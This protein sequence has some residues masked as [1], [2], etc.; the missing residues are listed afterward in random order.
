M[1]SNNISKYYK[2]DGG[3][4][5]TSD[6]QFA[7]LSANEKIVYKPSGEKY[8]KNSNYSNVF[9][10]TIS[11]DVSDLESKV[12]T[13][14]VAKITDADANGSASYYNV[15]GN[16]IGEFKC[17]LPIIGSDGNTNVTAVSQNG[18]VLTVEV[19]R[20]YYDKYGRVTKWDKQTATAIV[21][22]GSSSGVGYT[23]VPVGTISMWAGSVS[24]IP[25]GWHLCDGTAGTPD[26]RD[27]FVIGAGNKYN[28]GSTGGSASYDL[29]KH[30]HYVGYGN[31]S[32]DGYHLGTE[33]KNLKSEL[34]TIPNAVVKFNDFEGDSGRGWSTI[35]RNSTDG[36]NG[37]NGENLITSL[38]YA[39]GT[40]DVSG[41]NSSETLPPYYALCYIMKV[42]TD[43]SPTV[44]T[45]N[46]PELLWGQ[47]LTVGEVD[48]KALTVRMPENPM[49]AGN[50]L[51]YSNN[52][53]GSTTG[54][55]L[56]LEYHNAGEETSN[57]YTFTQT[58][59]Y[60]VNYSVQSEV[61]VGVYNISS[62]GSNNTGT[63]TIIVSGCAWK[64]V[65]RI[66]IVSVGEVFEV[67]PSSSYLIRT[68]LRTNSAL[69]GGDGSMSDSSLGGLELS[70]LYAPAK[71]RC[72]K[73]HTQHKESGG[74]SFVSEVGYY[75]LVEYL[76]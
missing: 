67:S 44:V 2:V 73:A 47:T 29:G 6:S 39:N 52:P 65:N 10:K 5:L 33:N 36:W 48:G 23:G 72:I 56:V 15:A 8:I 63:G 17:G 26:L 41:S 27:K 22:G 70:T 25:A 66:N 50:F 1:A 38:N 74:N 69:G 20:V 40:D 68:N 35:D 31:A 42:Q 64:D 13:K 16:K 18:N 57:H 24:D 58:G 75:Q 54:Y 62:S 61:P 49:G 14:T 9:D 30:Y 37:V 43:G 55:R 53:T 21:S 3:L 4:D 11:V 59:W 46:N 7:T 19:P 28:P 32:Q 60:I 51:Q 12:N 76:I 34:P 45:N 71:W